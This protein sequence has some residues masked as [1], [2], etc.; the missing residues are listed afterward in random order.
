MECI[1]VYLHDSEGWL[2]GGAQKLNSRDEDFAAM[3]VRIRKPSASPDN[4][5]PSTAQP[6]SE[7]K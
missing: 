2:A 3:K 1:C 5:S 7:K 4:Y 6:I